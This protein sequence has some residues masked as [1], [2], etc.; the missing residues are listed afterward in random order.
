MPRS[1]STGQRI[2]L[3][4]LLLLG[5]A[6]PAAGVPLP[7]RLKHDSKLAGAGEKEDDWQVLSYGFAVDPGMPG[8]IKRTT[9]L[10][11]LS[12][13]DVSVAPASLADG[14]T[15]Y[16][17]SEETRATKLAADA[18]IG[19]GYGPFSA[20]ASMKVTNDADSH[21]KTAR[22]D[23]TRSFNKL[24]VTARSVFRVLPQTRLDPAYTDYI[25]QTSIDDV[26]QLADTLGI[27][28]ARSANLGGLIRKTYTMQATETDT[29]SSL[30]AEMSAKYGGLVSGSAS[31]GETT[32]TRSNGATMSMS[33]HAQ[34]G[35]TSV[36]LKPDDNLDNIQREWAESFEDGGSLYPWG[37]ELRPIWEVI[38]KV[39]KAKGDALERH[40]TEKWAGEA[41]EFSPTHFFEPAQWRLGD[42]IMRSGYNG[43]RVRAVEYTGEDTVL[44]W[45]L[46]H[47]LC[48]AAGRATP[49]SDQ[50]ASRFDSI[51]PSTRSSREHKF[52]AY[53]ASDN[54]V[55]TD[56]C[57]W[58]L[59]AFTHVSG[60]LGGGLGYMCAGSYGDASS[61]F[62]GHD[63]DQQVRVEG[64]TAAGRGGQVGLNSGDAVFCSD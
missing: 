37:V 56:G 45:E 41:G 28:Y 15:V 58:P 6:A 52:C 55:V 53:S 36:W 4:A 42:M 24:R 54:H 34:G 7:L 2:A 8:F 27:F 43:A 62:G 11:R 63:C 19:G 48:A 33:F 47:S 20:A 12:E 22:L 57:H 9:Q 64:T 35:D 39:D 49:G 60:T 50:S 44:S 1:A 21:I 51:L 5:A 30:E 59:Q 29:R 26:A 40:L 10:F 16:S 17:T 46:Q 32:D 13:D 31:F 18:H 3:A 38:Q 61:W 14:E 25:Q 23:V